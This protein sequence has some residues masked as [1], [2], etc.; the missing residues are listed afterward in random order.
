MSAELQNGVPVGDKGNPQ[1][2]QKYVTLQSTEGQTRMTMC[3]PGRHVC[4][5]L[6]QKHDLVN[7]CT[8]CGR[9]VCAQVCVVRVCSEG[10]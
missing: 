8:G 5:C 6:A 7:N 1:K 9:I 4:E 10:V 2:K 3:F